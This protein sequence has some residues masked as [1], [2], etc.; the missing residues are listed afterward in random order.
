MVA[1][2]AAEAGRGS[3]GGEATRGSSCRGSLVDVV[4]FGPT[5]VAAP[6][7]LFY[8]LFFLPSSLGQQIEKSNIRGGRGE[9][10]RE[11]AQ[12]AAD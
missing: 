12:V 2:G 5:A 1:V 10:G 6:F 4:D 9:G 11:Q 7:S 3:A 8:A